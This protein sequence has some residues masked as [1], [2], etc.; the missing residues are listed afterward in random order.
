MDYFEWREVSN[1]V[2]CVKSKTSQPALVHVYA[3]A[4]IYTV[5]CPVFVLNCVKNICFE[6]KASVVYLQSDGEKPQH[7]AVQQSFDAG[8]RHYQRVDALQQAEY[9]A[10]LVRHTPLREVFQGQSFHGIRVLGVLADARLG[11]GD[12]SYQVGQLVQAE[13]QPV[14]KRITSL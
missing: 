13:L 9:G 11:G 5:N 2:K 3:T 12:A 14:D 10:G 1:V 4:N 8:V 7:A 6:I